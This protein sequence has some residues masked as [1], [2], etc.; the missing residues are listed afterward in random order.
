MIQV[1]A[2]T[3]NTTGAVTYCFIEA[4]ET[5]NAGTYKHIMDRMKYSLSTASAHATGGVAFGSDPITGALG[6]LLGGGGYSPSAAGF[7]QIPQ[8]SCSTP[9]DINRPFAL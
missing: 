4:I 3:R 9:F 7:S 6:L 8:L 1:H 2:L 5:G